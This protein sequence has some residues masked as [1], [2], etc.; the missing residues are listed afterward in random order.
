MTACYTVERGWGKIMSG[1]DKERG[2]IVHTCGSYALGNM[3]TAH[4][5]PLIPK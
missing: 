5:R 1:R 4:E 3:N 2:L